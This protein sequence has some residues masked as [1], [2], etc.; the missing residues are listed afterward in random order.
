[1]IKLVL[2][3]EAL[4]HLHFKRDEDEVFPERRSTFDLPRHQQGAAH[5]K[6]DDERVAY[7]D[8]KR[9]REREEIG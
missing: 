9:E 1:M 3:N 5:T 2:R 7:I 6:G 8:G 4:N